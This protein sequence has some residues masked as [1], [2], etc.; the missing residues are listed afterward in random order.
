[1]A[2]LVQADKKVTATQITMC[3]NSGVQKNI[4]DHAIY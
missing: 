1:M 2:K 3:Y 4:S